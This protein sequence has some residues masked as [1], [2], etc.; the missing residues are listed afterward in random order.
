MWQL[1]YAGLAGGRKGVPES[2]AEHL[3]VVATLTVPSLGAHTRG[4]DGCCRWWLAPNVSRRMG[5]YDVRG[6]AVVAT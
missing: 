3:Q 2:A 1:V 5:W 4:D 6:S